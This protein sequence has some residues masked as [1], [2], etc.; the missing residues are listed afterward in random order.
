MGKVS[1]PK[2]CKFEESM[3]DGY[4][5]NFPKLEFEYGGKR[6]KSHCAEPGHPM[7]SFIDWYIF[8]I[9]EPY[10]NRIL[11]SQGESIESWAMTEMSIQNYI[12]GIPCSREPIKGEIID[13]SYVHESSIDALGDYL[14]QLQKAID[15]CDRLRV[16]NDK[17]PIDSIREHESEVRRIYDLTLAEKGMP[18]LKLIHLG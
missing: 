13:G 15:C 8:N 9:L 17:W 10:S 18:F 2:E 5:G 4:N 12:A 14:K 3:L 6:V 7:A 1:L 16:P 11:G